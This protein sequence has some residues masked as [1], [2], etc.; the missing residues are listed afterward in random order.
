MVYV[1]LSYGSVGM[2]PRSPVPPHDFALLAILL[3]LRSFKAA[4]T[5]SVL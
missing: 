5:A 3:A 4:R 2:T 1:V